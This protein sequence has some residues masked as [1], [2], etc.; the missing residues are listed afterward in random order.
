MVS[1]AAHLPGADCT[2][3]VLFHGGMYQNSEQGL[4]TTSRGGVMTDLLHAPDGQLLYGVQV[5]DSSMSLFSLQNP[6]VAEVVLSLR[7]RLDNEECASRDTTAWLE[8]DCGL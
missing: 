3:R 6:A 5:S 2:D 7:F 4:R 1:S 8:Q